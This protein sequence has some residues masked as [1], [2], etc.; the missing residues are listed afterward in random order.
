M[1]PP[2]PLVGEPDCRGG[3]H[4][5]AFASA[6]VCRNGA[7]GWSGIPNCRGR[8]CIGPSLIP[9]AK[10]GRSRF[11]WKQRPLCRK[12]ISAN[13][14]VTPECNAAPPCAVRIPA[15][16]FAANGRRADDIRPYNDV[17]TVG[18]NGRP[19]RAAPPFLP[20]I[21]RRPAPIGCAGRYRIGPYVCAAGRPTMRLCHKT[22]APVKRRPLFLHKLSIV[23]CQLSITK[24]LT[25]R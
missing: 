1:W 15:S 17:N 13:G 9:P 14:T 18:A 25:C 4:P 22:T 11:A 16:P 24:S 8:S 5:P 19:R 10:G 23:N 6:R 20:P 7:H 12:R 21:G 3:Y 2:F